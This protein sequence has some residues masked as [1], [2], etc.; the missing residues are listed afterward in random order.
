VP[1]APAGPENALDRCN[2][3]ASPR[4]ALKDCHIVATPKLSPTTA[5]MAIAC[6]RLATRFVT[7]RRT[8]CELRLGSKGRRMICTVASLQVFERRVDDPRLTESADASNADQR[9]QGVF[10]A[11]I[12][13]SWVG[14]STGVRCPDELR[15][16]ASPDRR[17]QLTILGALSWCSVALS[18]GRARLEVVATSR[19]PIQQRWTAS[20]Q[21]TSLPCDDTTEGPLR[22]HE[23]ANSDKKG[24]VRDQC[25]RSV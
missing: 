25:A 11:L 22:R 3:C 4:R 16:S 2:S 8:F 23:R 19:Y 5:V 7:R 21:T 20:D 1:V 14:H 10:R 13:R 17:M 18:R 24:R 9:S 15:R 6:R 12:S